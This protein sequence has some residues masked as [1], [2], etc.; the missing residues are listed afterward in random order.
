MDA[1]F[2]AALLPRRAFSRCSSSES[3]GEDSVC[4]TN[5]AD[6]HVGVAS[7]ALRS[8]PDGAVGAGDDATDSL[9]EFVLCV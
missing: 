1:V 9:K 7:L 8:K 3:A 6:A 5:L 4:A 2:D